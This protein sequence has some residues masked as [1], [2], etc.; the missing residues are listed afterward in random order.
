MDASISMRD[1]GQRS[2]KDLSAA[3]HV[4][5][6]G[7]EDFPPLVRPR[8]AAQPARACALMRDL[9]RLCALLVRTRPQRHQDSAV[10]RAPAPCFAVKPVEITRFK[11][12][13]R[14]TLRGVSRDRIG[15]ASP[16]FHALEAG[17]GG[18]AATSSGGIDT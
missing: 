16:R 17:N 5:Q 12:V 14:S 15:S 18:L 1:L 10:M 7:N 2:L 4:Y 6:L 8:C 11:S 9:A 3:E 13:D